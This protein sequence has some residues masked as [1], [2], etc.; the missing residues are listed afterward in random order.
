MLRATARR[1]F[2]VLLLA[3]VAGCGRSELN[4][5][6]DEN[7][8][9]PS[10]DGPGGDDSTTPPD[11]VYVPPSEDAP[12]IVPPPFED[13][14]TC[15]SFDCDGCC[16]GDGTCLSLSNM[17]LGPG[18]CGANGEAC[19]VCNQFCYMGA[20]GNLD[21]NCGPSSCAGCCAGNGACSDGTHGKACGTGGSGCIDCTA[22]GLTCLFQQCGG[23]FNH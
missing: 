11:D 15:G 5:L 18:L 3:W 21:S 8:G 14:G 16:Q 6:L 22:S 17:P 1:T 2:A 20:C 9:V 12:Y 7:V 23:G 4:D 13:A 10:D 19:T